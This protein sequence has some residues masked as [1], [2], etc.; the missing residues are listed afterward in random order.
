MRHSA[1]PWSRAMPHS[2]RSK[3]HSSDKLIKLSH[4]VWLKETICRKFVHRWFY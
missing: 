4:D 1:W 3:W 2:V